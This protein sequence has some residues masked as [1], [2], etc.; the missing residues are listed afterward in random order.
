MIAKMDLAPVKQ[1]CKTVADRGLR[2]LGYWGKSK[3]RLRIPVSPNFHCGRT[4][5]LSSIIEV[6]LGFNDK[7][8]HVIRMP[9]IVAR[10]SASNQYL[11][12]SLFLFLRT[13]NCQN[14]LERR[15]PLCHS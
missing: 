13:V 6:H 4:A 10:K 12:L 2:Q 15:S 14:I 9:F 8:A 11:W 7:L 3:F 5:N 1:E